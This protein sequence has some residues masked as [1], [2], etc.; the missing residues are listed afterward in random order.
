MSYLV[1]LIPVAL[2]MGPVGL[3]ADTSSEI[4]TVQRRESS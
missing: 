3:C 1:V 2:L 4:W